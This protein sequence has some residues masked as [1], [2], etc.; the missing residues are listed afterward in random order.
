VGVARKFTEAALYLSCKTLLVQECKVTIAV[1][2][3]DLQNAK[4]KFKKI[5]PIKHTCVTHGMVDQESHKL[6]QSNK[7]FNVQHQQGIRY[8]VL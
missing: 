2:W 4:L 6:G 3:N 8:D 1:E 7:E 5:A